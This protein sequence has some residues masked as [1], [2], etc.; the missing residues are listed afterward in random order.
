MKPHR[1]ALVALLVVAGM[2]ARA[3]L[4]QLQNL[5]QREFREL[6]EDLGAALSYKALAPAAP[7]GV[8]G[9]DVGVAAT[10]TRIKHRDLFERASSTGDFP[11]TAP[12]PSLRAAAGL[13]WNFDVAIAYSPVPKTGATLWGGA[14]KWAV[15]EGGA[16]MPAIAARASYTTL[17]GLDQLNFYTSALDASI[18]KGVGPLTPYIGGGKVWVNSQ[19]TSGVTLAK[20][21]FGQTKLFGGVALGAGPVNFVVEYDRTGGVNTYGAKLG[22]KF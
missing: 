2:P 11:S 3:E 8:P 21:S 13:P 16:T 19:P 5:S 9:F 1:I 22:L 18:S 12:V 4:N 20:E 17:R 10:G 15:L 7:L 14:L 6:S